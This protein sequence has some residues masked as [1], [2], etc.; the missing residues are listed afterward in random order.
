[1]LNSDGPL[2]GEDLAMVR[3][4]LENCIKLLGENNTSQVTMEDLLC[5]YRCYLPFMLLDCGVC[6]LPAGSAL[7]LH[8][9]LLLLLTRNTAPGGGRYL[10]RGPV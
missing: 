5:C 1:M 2:S 10:G 4:L 3:L 7:H 9:S 6:L 8:G